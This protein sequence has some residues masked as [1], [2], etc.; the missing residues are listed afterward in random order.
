MRRFS[1]RTVATTAASALTAS[2]MAG[3]MAG[4]VF[5][6]SAGAQQG[7]G[8]V[9][10]KGASMPKGAVA[11]GKEPGRTLFVCRANHARGIHPGKVV[12]GKCNFG[13]GGREILSTKFQ[14]MVNRGARIGWVP[15]R[16]GK[17][18]SNA[19]V[20]GKEPGRTLFVCRAPHNGGIH[21]GKVVAGKCNIGYGGKEIV[22]TK[23]EA[24]VV[25]KGPATPPSAA[26][27]PKGMG[28]ALAKGNKLPAGAV[29]GGYERGRPIFLCRAPSQGGLLPGKLIG[30][31]C[32]ISAG[33]REVSAPKYQVL[34]RAGQAVRWVPAKAV[35]DM[36]TAFPGGSGPRVVQHA[37]AGRHGAGRHPG[38]LVKGVC[39]IAYG[40]KEIPL[41]QYNVLVNR[42]S[43][44]IGW[45][46]APGGRI[47]GGAVSGETERGKKLY[48]CRGPLSGG[49]IIGKVFARECHVGYYGR[50]HKIGKFQVMVA[51]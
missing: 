20:G 11:A 22:S 2:V 13:Y 34:V 46:A 3:V 38:K 47:P 26:S 43:A 10:G 8:W 4:M 25:A 39:Y 41:R 51:K 48:V 50:A 6:S 12:A 17:L 29:R 30:K 45:V 18:P 16:G 49:L 15:P 5:V 23:Y 31:R 27:L 40:A 36:R 24:M 21:P 35:K 9:P 32:I 19:Y 37:C 28:W 44:K 14:V 42:G 1:F 33:G 7:I